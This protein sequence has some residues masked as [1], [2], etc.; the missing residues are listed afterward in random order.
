L[1]S[2][3]KNTFVGKGAGDSVNSGYYNTLLGSDAAD[4]MSTGFLN[5]VIGLGAGANDVALTTGDYNTLLGALADTSISD[6]QNQIVIGY[7]ALGHGNNIAVI[8]DTNI[9]AWHPPD[10]NGVDLGSPSYRFANI[11][12]TDLQL[13][14]E[15]TEGNEIDGTTG[16]W[17]IQEGEEDLYLLN[18]KNGKKYK[19]NL[20]EIE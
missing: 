17:T 19:F 11:Y 16:N 1:T 13:A 2:G 7:N 14:N 20:T 12:T 18:R 5:T 6:A 3:Y 4:A 9:T 10:D 15:G 8:G